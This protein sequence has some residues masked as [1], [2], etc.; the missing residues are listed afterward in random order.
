MTTSTLWDP[1]QEATREAL[2]IEKKA[3]ANAKHELKK[4]K[5]GSQAG[6]DAE[7]LK[8]IQG[9]ETLI[10]ECPD[11]QGVRLNQHTDILHGHT[12]QKCI[13][14]CSNIHMLWESFIEFMMM[15]IDEEVPEGATLEQ[16]FTM[17]WD[18]MT[19]ADMQ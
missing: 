1:T 6:Q 4:K 13:N 19:S 10:K 15:Y 5:R 3:Y 9:V 2:V 12:M 14:A 18:K 11:L 8:V 17:V 7:V 16:E